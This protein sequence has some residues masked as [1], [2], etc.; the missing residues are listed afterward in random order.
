MPYV[1]KPEF[2]KLLLNQDHD[3]LIDQYIFEG[4]PFAFRDAPEQ[5][6]SLVAHIAGELGLPPSAINLVGSAPTGIQSSSRQIWDR[7]L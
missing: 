2:D 5:Y 6:E 4:V 1:T 7:I 3:E